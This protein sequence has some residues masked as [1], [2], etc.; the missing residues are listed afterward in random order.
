MM[1][2]HT[3]DFERDIL[4][5]CF[6]SSP[7]TSSN[8]V[9]TEGEQK[10]LDELILPLSHTARNY[11]CKWEKPLLKS[12]YHNTVEVGVDVS[13]KCNN[14]EGYK[15]DPTEDNGMALLYCTRVLF[16]SGLFQVYWRSSNFYFFV[17]SII[18]FELSTT[19]TGRKIVVTITI[20]MK[21]RTLMAVIGG[22]KVQP[23]SVI[24]IPTWVLIPMVNLIMTATAIVVLVTTAKCQ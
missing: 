23:F 5:R 2:K 3:D 1:R 12:D 13:K 17:T 14:G 22:S 9:C 8:E 11:K 6:L 7:E 15:D 20:P 10:H 16:Q 19:P 21:T 18:Y 4:E 24:L